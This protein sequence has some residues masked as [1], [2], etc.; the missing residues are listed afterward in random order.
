MKISV[1]QGRKP[2][3]YGWVADGAYFLSAFPALVSERPRNAYATKEEAEA[4]AVARGREIVWE[5]AVD[6]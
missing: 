5:D 6:G 3:V 4:E 1:R 2:P